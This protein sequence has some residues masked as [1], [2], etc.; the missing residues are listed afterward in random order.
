MAAIVGLC[1]KVFESGWDHLPDCSDA[2]SLPDLEMSHSLHQPVAEAPGSPCLPHSESQVLTGP[3]SDS[4]RDTE[5]R[6]L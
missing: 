5:R 4:K 3:G 1:P 2:L 6:N